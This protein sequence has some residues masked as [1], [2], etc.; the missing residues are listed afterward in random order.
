MIGQLVPV[1]LS[2]S[3]LHQRQLN[4]AQLLA[5]KIQRHISTLNLPKTNPIIQKT[6]GS[7]QANTLD[8]EQ[9]RKTVQNIFEVQF[10]KPPQRVWLVDD[11][12]TSGASLNEIV[13]VFKQS[14]V[15]FVGSLT[16]ARRLLDS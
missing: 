5:L 3:R 4:Q 10:T 12:T 9:R 15:T 2:K 13:R 16:L 8:I 6:Q 1:P 14:G 11:V 7:N